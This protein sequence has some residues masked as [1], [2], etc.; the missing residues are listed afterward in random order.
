MT[1]V[2]I[3]SGGG[4]DNEESFRPDNN[5]ADPSKIQIHKTN[6]NNEE[7]AKLFNKDVEKGKGE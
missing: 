3:L 2:K 5:N 6:E 1:Y 4:L 7:Y